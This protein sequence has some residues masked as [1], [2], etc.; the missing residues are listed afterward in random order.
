MTAERRA[1]ATVRDKAD[2]EADHEQCDSKNQHGSWIEDKLLGL[3]GG[4]FSV[5]LGCGLVGR[6]CHDVL[7]AVSDRSFVL[8]V[9]G[10]DRVTTRRHVLAG[11]GQPGSSS[12]YDLRTWVAV[13][14]PNRNDPR[15][16]ATDHLVR[17]TTR[18]SNPPPM[19]S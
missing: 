14:S 3:C 19:L 4:P 11:Q 10:P 13:G 9:S 2:D 6:E 8:L 7:S 5:A 12:K 16:L 1:V 18:T 17:A 15:Y